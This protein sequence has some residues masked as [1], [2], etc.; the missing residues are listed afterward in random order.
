MRIKHEP[1]TPRDWIEARFVSPRDGLYAVLTPQEIGALKRAQSLAE[2]LHDACLDHTLNECE[3]DI[4]EA[5]HWADHA[6]RT[7]LDACESGRIILES[8]DLMLKPIKGG[9]K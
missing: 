3:S 7:L 2:R 5:C 4:P 6:L 8:D 1:I 9:V